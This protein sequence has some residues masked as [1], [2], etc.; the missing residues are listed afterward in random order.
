MPGASQDTAH[1][2]VRRMGLGM[3][4][5]STGGETLIPGTSVCSQ[6]QRAAQCLPGAPGVLLQQERVPKQQPVSHGHITIVALSPP[7]QWAARALAPTPAHAWDSL[8]SPPHPDIYHP[9]PPSATGNLG[10]RFPP[11]WVGSGPWRASRLLLPHLSG[12]S[13]YASAGAAS[14]RSR[15]GG[16]MWGG[17][18]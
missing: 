13:S 10:L 9:Q 1:T 16:H 6:P 3:A 12:S 2:G 15:G 7:S 11:R 8:T 4:V 14:R 17:P 5:R 18:V